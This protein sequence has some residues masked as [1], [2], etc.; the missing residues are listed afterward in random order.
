MSVMWLNYRESFPYRRYESEDCAGWKQK[1][2][3]Q[4]LVRAI[5]EFF[6]E[7]PTPAHLGV[8]K[9]VEACCR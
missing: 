2:V 5:L 3:P 9:T 6:Y 7:N 4:L 1:L 8:T